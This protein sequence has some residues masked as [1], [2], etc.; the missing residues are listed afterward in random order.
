MKIISA[1]KI[2]IV[3]F[4]AMSYMICSCGF[5]SH[6][7]R[8]NM[9]EPH[10]D[11]IKL[12]F[13]TTVGESSIFVTKRTDDADYPADFQISN[14]K[15]YLLNSVDKKLIEVNLENGKYNS[16]RKVDSVM[17]IEK[18]NDGEISE[19]C[20]FQVTKDFFIIGYDFKIM[21]FSKQ[22]DLL[23]RLNFDGWI[24]LATSNMDK[25]HIRL[26]FYDKSIIIDLQKG[27]TSKINY[28]YDAEITNC[29]G[30]KD[31]LI[32]NDSVFEIKDEKFLSKAFAYKFSNNPSELSNE[33]W[34]IKCVSSK[35]YVWCAQSNNL[36]LKLMEK[37]NGR[38]KIKQLNINI[39][40]RLYYYESEEEGIKIASDE[41][42]FFILIMMPEGSKK[43]VRIYQY[44]I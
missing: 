17:A 10:R 6:V 29:V 36:T 41:T 23:Y 7:N 14:S 3:F 28:S 11:S 4:V 25:N 32:G 43:V 19:P 30:Y 40:E 9:N 18:N 15:G 31:E 44:V 1:I 39:G 35:Y 38:S 24:Y 13:E 2:V 42:S 37:Q 26:W 27:S 16:M 5:D 33:I 34:K 8:E 20:F 22:Q 21:V 12:V